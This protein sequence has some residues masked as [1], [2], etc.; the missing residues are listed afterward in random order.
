MRGIL[1]KRKGVQQRAQQRNAERLKGSPDLLA[2]RRKSKAES[3]KK[4]HWKRKEMSSTEGKKPQG[5]L[6]G[7]ASK[8]ATL[9]G[10]QKNPFLQE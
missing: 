8:V 10:A 4:S 3:E 6:R 2:C 5:L 9:A 1:E 7:V